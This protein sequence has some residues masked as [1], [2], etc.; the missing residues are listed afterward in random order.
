VTALVK[1]L[2][3][4]HAFLSGSWERCEGGLSGDKLHKE[5]VQS[6]TANPNSWMPLLK[7]GDFLQNNIARRLAKKVCCYIFGF[8]TLIQIYGANRN[9][10]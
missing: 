10:D 9:D 4:S 6:K 5:C 7:N 3:L 2:P 1:L 8:Y